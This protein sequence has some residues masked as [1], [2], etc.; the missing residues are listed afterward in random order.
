MAEEAEVGEAA[1]VA[2][3]DR[4]LKKPAAADK[5]VRAAKK[6]R[7]EDR[8]HCCTKPCYTTSNNMFNYNFVCNY[9]RRRPQTCIRSDL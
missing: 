6:H 7:V 2:E 1:E 4:V 3:D 8:H 5:K 9:N